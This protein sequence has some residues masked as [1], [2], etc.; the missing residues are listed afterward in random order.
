MVTVISDKLTIK[1]NK[2]LDEIHLYIDGTYR[3]TLNLF[4]VVRL[5]GVCCPEV[6]PA[7]PYGCE[8]RG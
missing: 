8:P 1:R 2:E 5:D 6:I 3:C 7:G 4:E